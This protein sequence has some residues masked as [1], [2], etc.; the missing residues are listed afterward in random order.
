MSE[1]LARSVLVFSNGLIAVCDERGEQ[2]TELQGADTPELRAIIHSRSDG[3]THWQF[4]RRA[5]P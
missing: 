4:A 1:P 5:R 3:E 2:I